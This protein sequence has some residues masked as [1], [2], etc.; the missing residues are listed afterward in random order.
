MILRCTARL[1]D[2]LNV[3][4]AGIV[5]LRPS[6]DDWY[7]NLLWVDG[8]KCLLLTHAGTLFSVFVA[9]ARKADLRPLG[10]YIVDRIEAELRSESLPVDALGRLD[11]D[12]VC[13]AK[14]GS[15]STLGFMNEVAF[16]CRY[17]LLLPAASAD[18]TSAHSLT[19]SGGHC[20]TR[21]V[22]PARSNAWLSG[23]IRAEA[24]TRTSKPARRETRDGPAS[25][26][27]NRRGGPVL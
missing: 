25:R 15:R 14:T 22:T 1:R 27:S 16:Q 5:E 21:P 7:A 9:G 2:P 18:A 20:T 17:Q 3:R 4:A 24:T 19:G 23:S 10:P 26:Q 8:T 11:A 13:L 6:D 12:T